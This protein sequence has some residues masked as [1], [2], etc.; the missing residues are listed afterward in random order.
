MHQV[1]RYFDHAVS[2][3]E[4]PVDKRCVINSDRRIEIHAHYGATRSRGELIL[5]LIFPPSSCWV[6][7]PAPSNIYVPKPIGSLAGNESRFDDVNN[8]ALAASRDSLS[9]DVNT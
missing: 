2:L 3:L 4:E 9:F 5:E 6:G 8:M 1:S 7:D